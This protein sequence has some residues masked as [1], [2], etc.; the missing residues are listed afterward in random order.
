MVDI[1][2][3][4]S[5]WWTEV[6]AILIWSFFLWLLSFL[7]DKYKF[8]KRFCYWLKVRKTICQIKLSIPVRSNNS[9]NY[10]TD[11]FK[12]YW[13][14]NAVNVKETP[15]NISYCSKTS[16]SAYDIKYV[17]DDE[18]EK[19][20]VTIDNFNGFSVGLFG[21]LRNLKPTIN[22]LKKISQ[23][24]DNDRDGTDKIIAEITITPRKKFFFNS[25]LKGEFKE[26]DYTCSFTTKTIHITN[27]GFPNLEENISKITYDWMIHFI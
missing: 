18:Q 5:K 26:E 21:E 4:F 14:N 20:F 24:F 8:H 10:L 17:E 6:V 9:Q 1:V 11:K 25:K 15:N 13:N 27:H 3:F 22:E 23:L 19:S 2:L 12:E 16:G 7:P